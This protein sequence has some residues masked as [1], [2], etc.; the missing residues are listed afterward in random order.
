[1]SFRSGG[2]C[3]IT[4]RVG[5]EWVDTMAGLPVRSAQEGWGNFPENWVRVGQLCV[6]AASHCTGHPHLGGAPW[7]LLIPQ[8]GL[9]VGRRVR[10]RMGEEREEWMRSF[11]ADSVK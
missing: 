2:S 5:S 7:L 11:L 4:D 9:G 3:E 8:E 6:N 10:V 1:M